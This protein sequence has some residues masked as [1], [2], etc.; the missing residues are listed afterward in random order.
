MGKYVYGGITYLT[1]EEA[2]QAK[3][4]RRIRLKDEIYID[5]QD[6]MYTACPVENKQDATWQRGARDLLFALALGS[7]RT[8]ETVIW[9]NRSLI[10]ITYIEM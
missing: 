3:K 2:E 4:E 7:G 10:Y 1:N 8:L 9:I 5:L 6:L